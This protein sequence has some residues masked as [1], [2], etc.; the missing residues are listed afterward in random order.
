MAQFA[1]GGRHR[2]AVAT[3]PAQ[4]GAW[5]V[6]TTGKQ[7]Q[8]M[9]MSMAAPCRTINAA[10]NKAGDGDV[11]NI[12]A[13]VYL[14]NINL[15]KSLSLV[16]DGQTDTVIDGGGIGPVVLITAE[17]AGTTANLSGLTLQNGEY[18]LGGGLHSESGTGVVTVSHSR[19]ISNTAYT[20]GG[21]IFSQGNLNLVDVLI[22]NNVNTGDAARRRP[23]QS[24]FS[25][26]DRH[27]P[28]QQHLQQ[29]GG[30]GNSGV[31]TLT[32]STID[33]NQ[34]DDAG[35]GVYTGGSGARFISS[36]NTYAGNHAA[37][38]AGGAI[39]NATS[40]IDT[41]S[42]ITG[43]LATTNGG[44]IYNDSTGQLTLNGTTLR[45]NQANNAFGGGLYNVGLA[46]LTGAT[47]QGNTATGSGGGL[48]STG[49]SSS[50]S[51][52]DTMVADNHADA[53]GGGIYAEP[54]PQRHP[55]PCQQSNHG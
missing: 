37:S 24:G 31:L 4:A 21:G 30:I 17:S 19:I 22:E 46:T 26:L 12:A 41:G 34:A 11:I 43:S 6:A 47:V 1:G 40:M 9:R 2:Q 3:P 38:S 36:N 51:L 49:T 44:G 29:G 33:N 13:G 53:N 32:A 20:G 8:F 28:R 15:S 42:L 16:G 27:H 45:N 39:Y 25:H 55:H 7:R 18:G 54:Q 10:I 52:V 50:L 14:E 23:V 5:Y 48:Y 35:G